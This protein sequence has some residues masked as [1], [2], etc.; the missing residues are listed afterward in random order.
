MSALDR[1][2][3]STTTLLSNGVLVYGILASPPVNVRLTY[4]YSARLPMSTHLNFLPTGARQSGDHDLRWPRPI[5]S[6]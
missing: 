5:T 6:S 2:I 4:H 1:H 3:L